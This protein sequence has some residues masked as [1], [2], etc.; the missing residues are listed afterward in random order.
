MDG[1]LPHPENGGCRGFILENICMVEIRDDCSQDDSQQGGIVRNAF[2]QG[3]VFWSWRPG[4]D[5]PAG[6]SGEIMVFENCL[7]WQKRQRYRPESGKSADPGGHRVGITARPIRIMVSRTQQ[8][9]IVTAIS[10]S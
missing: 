7:I 2:L 10:G 8:Q 4:G 9:L 3:H 6:K 1:F 5:S